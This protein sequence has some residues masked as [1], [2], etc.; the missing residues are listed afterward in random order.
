MTCAGS[1]TVRE[2]S[3]VVDTTVLLYLGRIGLSDLLPAQFNP[4]WVPEAVTM[5]LDMGRVLR[6]DTFDPHRQRWV[7]V[8][9][10]S[11]SLVDGLPT[12]RLGIGERAVIAFA[13]AQGSW[14]GLDDHQA[15]QLAESMGIRVIG[16]LGILVRAKRVSL[17][18]AVQP[19]LDELVAQGFRLGPDLYQDVL[20]LA[21]EEVPG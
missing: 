11:Q 5:E 1:L 8:V 14:A 18:S 4:V 16:T 7:N 2:R 6:P 10:A 3:I 13:Q 12:N 17:I 15:R 21:G 20:R 19:S 9:S